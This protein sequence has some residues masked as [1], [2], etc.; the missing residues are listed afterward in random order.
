MITAEQ[1]I[2]VLRTLDPKTEMLTRGYE[3]GY[4][5]IKSVVTMPTKVHRP[6]KDYYGVYDYS[7]S[8]DVRKAVLLFGNFYIGDKAHV[9]TVW[10]EA[11]DM[12]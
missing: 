7:E 3:S 5:P 10:E 11:D 6:A 8:G 2:E 9:E 4:D 12:G 1:L